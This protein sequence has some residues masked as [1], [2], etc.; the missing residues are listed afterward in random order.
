MHR[1]MQCPH[2]HAL[3]SGNRWP[4]SKA[5]RRVRGAV[6]RHL[7]QP[8]VD[9]RWTLIDRYDTDGRRLYVAVKNALEFQ[10]DRALSTREQ[11]VARIAAQGMANKEIAYALGLSVSSISTYL[12]RALDKL[13]LKS[14]AELPL[15][16]EQSARPLELPGSSLLVADQRFTAPT[17]LTEAENIVA[18]MAVRGLSDDDIARKRSRSVR[19]ILLRSTY[20]KLNVTNRSELVRAFMRS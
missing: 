4:S 5:R 2:T 8:L 10:S 17:G 7:W 9:R 6:T 18:L 15:V 14:R 13:R 11:Q 16:F 1:T 12:H 19:T 3:Y 20:K